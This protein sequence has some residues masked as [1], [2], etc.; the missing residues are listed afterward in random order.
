MWGKTLKGIDLNKQAMTYDNRKKI[1]VGMRYLSS[2]AKNPKSNSI[3]SEYMTKDETID[4]NLIIYTRITAALIKVV[5]NE[6]NMN[7]KRLNSIIKDSKTANLIRKSFGCS[8][9]I[10]ASALER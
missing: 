8:C 3:F 10:R 2:R 4:S 5:I 9:I 6:N 7:V 1:E